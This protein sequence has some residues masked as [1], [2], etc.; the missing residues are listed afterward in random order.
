MPFLGLGSHTK[1]TV[2]RENTTADGSSDGQGMSA[3]WLVLPV[4]RSVFL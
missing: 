3:S 4:T 2:L 1:M